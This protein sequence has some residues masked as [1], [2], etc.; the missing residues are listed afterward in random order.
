MNIAL[1]A[2]DEKKDLMVEFCMAYTAILKKHNLCATGTTGNIITN[3]TSL[4]VERFL[5]GKQG[6]T[7]QIGSRISFNE[8]DMLIFFRVSSDVV[9]NDPSV[10]ILLKLC[11]NYNVPFATNLATAEVLVRA[12]ERGELDWRDVVNPK[13]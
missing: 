2:H 6:G 7:E 10:S 3:L 13:F 9:S 11:D 4:N 5:V 8:I 12:L 1:A